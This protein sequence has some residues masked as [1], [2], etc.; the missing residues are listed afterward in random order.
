MATNRSDEFARLSRSAIR[1][2]LYQ[3][4]QIIKQ[5]F[6][7]SARGFVPPAW[8]RGQLRIDDI[9]QHG[10]RYMIGFNRAESVEKQVQLTTWNWDWGMASHLGMLA[11]YFTSLRQNLGLPCIVFHPLDVER[12]YL[13]R[14]ISCV[15]RLLAEGKRPVLFDEVFNDA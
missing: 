9:V 11:E 7:C 12:G 14:G 6:E 1:D 8:S 5:H 10:M 2:R 4:Q 13:E 15:K 3:G